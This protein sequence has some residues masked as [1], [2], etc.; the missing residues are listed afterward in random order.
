MA[1]LRRPVPDRRTASRIKLNLGCQFVFDKT[2]YQAVIKDISPM[3]ALLWSSFMPPPAAD[4]FIQIET[5]LLRIP[6]I[7]EGKIVRRDCINTEQGS[8]GA[9]AVKFSGQSPAL[10]VLINKIASPQI[11]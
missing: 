6:I 11:T 9:F 4:V 5:H 3:G 1:T 7:L 8:I 10:I 2:E